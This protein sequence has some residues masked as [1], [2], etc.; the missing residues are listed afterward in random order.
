[1]VVWLQFC[2]NEFLRHVEE[3]LARAWFRPN[4]VIKVQNMSL[5]HLY[6]QF[7]VKT[8]FFLGQTII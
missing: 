6:I 4:G 5:K 7:L 2:S 3:D 1:M 8:I